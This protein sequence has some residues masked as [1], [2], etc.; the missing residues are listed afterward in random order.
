MSE[1][2][3]RGGGDEPRYDWLYG[4]GSDRPSEDRPAPVGGRGRQSGPP[5]ADRGADRGVD[6]GAGQG[7]DADATRMIRTQ[8]R[9][10]PR[11]AQASPE[12]Q[13][14]VSPRPLAPEPTRERRSRGGLKRPT[15]W[16]VVKVVVLVWI[17]FLVAVPF[18]AW[19]KV[20]KVDA[21]PSGSRPAEQPGTTYL[22]VGSDSRAGLTPEERKRLGTGDAGGQRTDTIMLLHVGSG[23]N[24]LLSI[25]RDSIVPIPGHGTGKINAAFAYGG[26]KLLVQ[27]I[28]QS[29]GVR[30]DDYVE[31]GMGGVVNAVDAVGGVQIC[32][33][34]RL[35]DRRA[36]LRLS[37]G[38]HDDVDGATAL[39]YT[40]SRHTQRLGDIDRA[41]NQR[42]VV[43]Q[44]GSKVKSPLT[45]LNPFRY[46]GVAKAGSQSLVVNEGMS[47]FAMGRFAW[48]MTRV[49]GDNG[50]T[51]SMPIRDQ[52]IHWDRDRALRLMNLI[53]TDQT[54]KVGGLCTPTGFPA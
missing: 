43:S 46:V 26:P 32:T 51:C 53:K 14:P 8:P 30:V 31:I 54:S 27:T 50:L 35:V 41:K 23:P 42:A 29:T 47:V 39:A 44:V 12:Q 18:W 28:E 9:E 15:V 13:R 37:K 36:K 6:R 40:R 48:A 10:Q 2:S 11:S 5:S 3:G 45:V 24:L 34:K 25:P 49:N 7:A 4:G 20:E 21:A 38:C 19:S 52:A 1:Q 22:L 33:P 16:R 17:V